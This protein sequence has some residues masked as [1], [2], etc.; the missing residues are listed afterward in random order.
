MANNG[1]AS[2]HDHFQDLQDP[3]VDRTR[4][5]PLINIVFIAVCRVL[6]GANSFASIPEFATD[7]RHWFARYLDL[8][9][10]IPSD[11]T[12]ARVLARLDPGA[13]EKCLLVWIRAVQE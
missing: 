3:G 10:G 5:H 1:S 9:H 4:K 11:D 8:S 13:F 6:A 2:F 7:R 12:L